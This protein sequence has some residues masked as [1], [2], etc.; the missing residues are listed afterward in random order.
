MEANRYTE[1]I[2]SKS[3]PQFWHGSQYDSWSF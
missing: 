2:T 3:M 1:L